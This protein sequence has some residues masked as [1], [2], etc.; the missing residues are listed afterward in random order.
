MKRRLIPFLGALTVALL[1]LA[2]PATAVVSD[3]ATD[4][5]LN[6]LAVET[7]LADMARNVAGDRLAVDSLIPLEVDPHG[8]EPTPGDVRRVAESQVLI[9]N[10][11]GFEEFLERLLANAGGRRT[12]IV[13]SEGLTG[14][15]GPDGAQ[16]AAH[17]DDDDDEEDGHHAE[18]A[19]VHKDEAAHKGHQQ[20]K[21]AH[22]AHKGHDHDHAAHGGHH[23]H[24]DTDPHYWLDPNFVIHYVENIRDGLS[25][26]DP[27][28]ASTYAANASAYITRLRELDQ[29][30]REET[31]KVPEQSRVLVTN[32]ESFGYFAGRYGFR[33]VGTV[34]PSTSD[35]A[36]PSAR[37]LA[38]LVSVIR[39]T[40]APAIFL[41]TGSNPTLAKQVARETGATVVTDLQ[42][43]SITAQGGPAPTYIDMMRHNTRII[44]EALTKPAER[45]KP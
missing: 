14:W 31:A 30:I 32:H 7:F 20:D 10:G 43:H 34:I 15:K 19:G 26:V 44:V 23:H 2:G 4:P 5:T 6:V 24:G 39:K 22:Q 17:D 29:W 21:A 38:H 37:Q 12:L 36:S 42:T 35:T 8:F 45:K 40:G 1:L 25:Q 3:S 33:I 13:A 18:H 9:V 11:A 28:G 41:E 27:A 16:V